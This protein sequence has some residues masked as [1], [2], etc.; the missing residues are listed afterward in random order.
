MLHVV[1]EFAYSRLVESAEEG[2]YRSRH[3][4]VFREMVRES[5][6]EFE[7]AARLK[8]LDRLSADHDNIRAALDWAVATGDADSALTLVAGMWR[9]WQT[10]G[11]LPEAQDR[12][13]QALAIHGDSPVLRAHAL[14]A[15]GSIAYW[16]GDFAAM[17]TP[18]QEAVEI[19]REHGTPTELAQALYNLSFGMIAESDF[20]SAAEALDESMSIAESEGDLLGIARAHWGWFDLSW[21]KQE[22]S[23]ALRHAQRAAE[24]FEKVDAPFDLAWAHFAIGDTRLKLGALDEARASLCRGL[25]VF[26]EAGDLPALVLFL[27]DFAVLEFKAGD[28]K[29]AA[30][31]MGAVQAI[32]E[33]IGLSLFDA[34]MWEQPHQE[35]RELFGE[36][37]DDLRGEL[38]IGHR[39]TPDEA[40]DLALRRPKG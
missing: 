19:M 36:I 2:H 9:Y 29:R 8:W 30:R 28:R 14:E 32:R 15:A 25:P 5:D 34:A 17:T 23:D 18:Y 1:R 7:T 16:R 20:E 24:A 33:R 12:V 11:P 10:R 40:V 4:K 26:A 3:M 37:D 27:G 35:A 6:S 38:E 13:D 22:S 31:L 21:Y 39:M